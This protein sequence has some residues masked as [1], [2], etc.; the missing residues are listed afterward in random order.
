MPREAPYKTD[1]FVVLTA[2][3]RSELLVSKSN[4]Q[5]LKEGQSSLTGL[6]FPPN[7]MESVSAKRRVTT[8]AERGRRNNL[9]KALEDLDAVLSEDCCEEMSRIAS[10]S[11]FN[12][13]SKVPGPQTRTKIGT[14]K[15]A[16]EY[17]RCLQ[18][19]V[20]DLRGGQKEVSS[21]TSSAESEVVTVAGPSV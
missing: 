15:L 14:L 4:Y 2:Q 20:D 17:I 5:L 9:N 16:I 8:I 7:M 12:H 21:T 1:H 13:T 18:N 10:A 11:Q 19:E 3:R 6:T